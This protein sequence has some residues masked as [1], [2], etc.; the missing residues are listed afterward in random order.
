MAGPA[1]KKYGGKVLVRCLDADSFKDD[2]IGIFMM[3]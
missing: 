2:I 3:I 1:I